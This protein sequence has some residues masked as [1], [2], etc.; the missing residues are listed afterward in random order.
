[1]VTSFPSTES[2]FPKLYEGVGDINPS[3]HNCDFP[4]QK[5]DLSHIGWGQE[6]KGLQV[7]LGMVRIGFQDN[8]IVPICFGPF[9]P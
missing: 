6:S 3:I 9:Q 4:S 5:S 7:R 2:Q 1:M 8:Q